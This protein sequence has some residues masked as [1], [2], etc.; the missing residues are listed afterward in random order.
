[1]RD[2]AAHEWGTRRD[3]MAVG[4]TW[5]NADREC[6]LILDSYERAGAVREEESA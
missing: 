2:E 6:R 3:A 4:F 1:M 5:V